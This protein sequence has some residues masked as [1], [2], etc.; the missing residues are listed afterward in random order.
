MTIRENIEIEG[1]RVPKVEE[2]RPEPPRAMSKSAKAAEE[3]ARKIIDE[4]GEVPTITGKY[5]VPRAMW[6]DGWTYEWK[7]ISVAGK[8]DEHHAMEMLRAGWKFVPVERH[9]HLMPKGSKGNIIDG[10]LA[11]MELPTV[12]VEMRQ[13]AMRGE[14]IDQ[15]ASADQKLTETPANTAPRNDP[16]LARH[17]INKIERDL[18]RPVA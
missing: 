10:G 4:V 7:R 18:L 9:E 8:D 5:D 2:P 6:P 16:S 12:L 17:G 13:R 1:L 3:Y 15:I 14:A 11:L